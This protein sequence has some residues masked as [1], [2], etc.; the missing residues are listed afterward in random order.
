VRAD[1]DSCIDG[2]TECFS[3]HRRDVHHLLA[4]DRCA[5][6]LIEA[7]AAYDQRAAARQSARV[8]FMVEQFFDV[9]AVSEDA[10]VSSEGTVSL[11][12]RGVSQGGYTRLHM[13]VTKVLPSELSDG[14]ANLSARN[15]WAGDVVSFETGEPVN[16]ALEVAKAKLRDLVASEIQ[17][18]GWGV[19]GEG[20]ID[21]QTFVGV[22]REELGVQD[23]DL[24]DQA[25]VD[26][27]A[28]AERSVVYGAGVSG[29][30][31]ASW[32]SKVCDAHEASVRT[33]V[34]SAAFALQRA[35]KT[36]IAKCGWERA[37][38]YFS[39]DELGEVRFEEFAVL[40]RDFSTEPSALPRS[41]LRQI[42]RHLDSSRSGQISSAQVCTWI[43][44][45]PMEQLMSI[46]SLKE[47][48][49][50]LSQLWVEK[51]DAVDAESPDRDFYFLQWLFEAVT[52]VDGD[53][54]DDGSKRRLRRLD[55]LKQ[56]GLQNAEETGQADT[57]NSS[58]TM[59]GRVQLNSQK[60]KVEPPARPK[61]P[62]PAV[63]HREPLFVSPR[64]GAASLQHPEPKD[65][66]PNRIF[67][68][69]VRLGKTAWTS[70]CYASTQHDAAPSET[71]LPPE[72]ASGQGDGRSA[73]VLKVAG[74][75]HPVHSDPRDQWSTK[76]HPSSSRQARRTTGSGRL[77]GRAEHTPPPR[78]VDIA[79]KPTSCSDWQGSTYVGG[80][81]GGTLQRPATAGGSRGASKHSVGLSVPVE[82]PRLPQYQSTTKDIVFNRAEAANNR[83]RQ[84][85]RPVSASPSTSVRHRQ[86]TTKHPHKA[87]SINHSERPATAPVRC[88]VVERAE[89]DQKFELSSIL[90]AAVA[91]EPGS[92]AYN[93][94]TGITER[95]R[96]ESA[97]RLY[98]MGVQTRG[99]M[100]SGRPDTRPFSARQHREMVRQMTPTHDV[101][102][103]TRDQVDH[104]I[105]SGGFQYGAQD[106]ATLT[107]Y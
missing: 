51:V 30:E 27:F 39:T 61:P 32:L 40:T 73:T 56:D 88:R 85:P 26:V 11:Q 106:G 107:E 45:A 24:D 1:C 58:D 79:V 53:G 90:L 52:C 13:L 59:P 70:A 50:Q 18:E 77:L 8:S 7:R 10:K 38:S 42:F 96:P 43:E 37:F 25:L 31:F 47:G 4:S 87:H 48:L 55:E 14:D 75:E 20:R 69:K 16:A 86:T 99:P 64:I 97:A 92:R 5:A 36:E 104:L 105:V 3:L 82:Q 46:K 49:L 66:N 83:A 19:L 93:G 84:G 74:P 98:V 76:H 78:V 33:P 12:K 15:D 34:T 41:S 103:L 2:S 72:Q 9:L 54:G 22:C 89:E 65:I 101:P 102:R 44:N 29:P 80:K 95:T 6:A 100:R 60:K 71:P 91:K 62:K 21:A 67:H 81:R 68:S 28:Q 94:R 35:S 23:T 63:I 17:R 57:S